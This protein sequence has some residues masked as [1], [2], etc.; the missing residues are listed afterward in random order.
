MRKMGIT[1][2]MTV[3]QALELFPQMFPAFQQLGMCCVNPDNENLS[4]QA[5]CDQYDT[6]ADAFLEA[7]N[8]L[9]A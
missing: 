9:L 7:V 8:G 1:P 5:L 4:V 2:D 6:D 3:G